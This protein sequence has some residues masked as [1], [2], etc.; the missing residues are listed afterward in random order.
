MTLEREHVQHVRWF[1]TSWGAPVCTPEYRIEVP[2]GR[3]CLA[4]DDLIAEWHH[5]L[6]LYGENVATEEN[7][8]AGRV[9]RDE[10]GVARCAYHLHCFVRAVVPES[11]G[12]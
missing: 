8:A 4:C 2:K 7:V 11:G 1:G 12:T 3:K 5:G 10:E 9:W 6:V